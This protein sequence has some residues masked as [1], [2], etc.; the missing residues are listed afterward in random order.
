MNQ[1]ADFHKDRYTPVFV[2][3][4][5]SIFPP[6]SHFHIIPTAPHIHLWW[7]T[8]LWLDPRLASFPFIYVPLQSFSF[9]PFIVFTT[10][11]LLFVRC[12]EVSRKKE[13][14]SPEKRTTY[15]MSD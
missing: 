11:F 10:G 15:E 12:D 14:L 1:H 5:R 3:S 7:K 8:V 13:S 9:S 2:Q 4:L 6:L